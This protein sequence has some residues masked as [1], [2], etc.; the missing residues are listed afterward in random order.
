MRQLKSSSWR[1]VHSK[2]WP[3][4]ADGGGHRHEIN[5]P[6]ATVQTMCDGQELF[7]QVQSMI[8]GMKALVE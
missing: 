7:Q 5:T 6:L 8:A 3:R 1:L 2:K 4:S